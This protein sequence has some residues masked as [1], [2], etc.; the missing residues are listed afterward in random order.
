MNHDQPALSSC[1]IYKLFVINVHEMK[2]IFKWIEIP[3]YFQREEPGVM[4]ADNR[5]YYRAEFVDNAAQI[6]K[7]ND[8]K[9]K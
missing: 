3:F 9:V 2:S 6:S 8:K 5:L 4:F 1:F 7:G